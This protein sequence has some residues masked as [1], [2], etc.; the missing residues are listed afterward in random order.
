MGRVRIRSFVEGHGVEFADCG[1]HDI[2][3]SQEWHSARTLGEVRPLSHTQPRLEVAH[4]HRLSE[5][6]GPKGPAYAANS[7]KSV[8]R[9]SK[10]LNQ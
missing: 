3:H 7:L 5:K 4:Q 2:E 8:F 9:R 1:M 10:W 6:S